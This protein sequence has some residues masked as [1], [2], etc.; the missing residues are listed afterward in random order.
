MSTAT[1]IIGSFTD[2][3]LVRGLVALLSEG[4]ED[5]GDFIRHV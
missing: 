1:Y 2:R 3:A 5:L 4:L